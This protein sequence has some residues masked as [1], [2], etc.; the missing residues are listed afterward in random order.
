VERR[1]A[2][3]RDD[4]RRERGEEEEH[5]AGQCREN[6]VGRLID[7][8]STMD[9]GRADGHGDGVVCLVHRCGFLEQRSFG[10]WLVESVWGYRFRASR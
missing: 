4:G 10:Q 7:V 8:R 9:R 3:T 5:E 2:Q 1:N 6:E